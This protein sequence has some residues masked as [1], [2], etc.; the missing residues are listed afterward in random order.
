MTCLN[1]SHSNRKN[2]IRPEKLP[3][4]N[5]VALA[6]H[7]TLSFAKVGSLITASIPQFVYMAEPSSASS[8][9]DT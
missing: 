9:I 2:A 7:H 5:Y 8:L 3:G 4:Q 6:Y 1:S